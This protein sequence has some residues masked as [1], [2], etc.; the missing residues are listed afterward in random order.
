MLV[1]NCAKL[2]PEKIPTD[3]RANRKDSSRRNQGDSSRPDRAQQKLKA[4]GMLDHE[5][6]G[7]KKDL[8]SKPIEDTAGEGAKININ[9]GGEV[10]LEAV[11]VDKN[12]GKAPVDAM[13]DASTTTKGVVSPAPAPV[14]NG[15]G[16]PPD[17]TPHNEEDKQPKSKEKPFYCKGW[18]W[19][20]V[21]LILV[22]GA[23]AIFF[24]TRI[25]DTTAAVPESETVSGTDPDPTESVPTMAPVSSSPSGSPSST[26]SSLVLLDLP[27]S[28]EDCA[29]IANG[30]VVPGQDNTVLQ[31]YQVQMDVVLDS[32]Y[33]DDTTAQ[34]LEEKI[35]ALFMPELAGC[36]IN[37]ERRMLRTLSGQENLSRQSSSSSDNVKIESATTFTLTNMIIQVFGPEPELVTKLG[38]PQ[39]FKQ[40][41]IVS[42]GATG[43]G[44]APPVPPSDSSATPS[45]SP[46]S[47]P[48]A[49]AFSNPTQ[50]PA[51]FPTT[52]EPTLMPSSLP[53]ALPTPDI[54]I[55]VT[56]GPTP[57][58]TF[59]PVLDATPLP[60]SQPSQGPTQLP[61]PLRTRRPAQLPSIALSSLPSPGPSSAPSAFDGLGVPIVADWDNGLTAEEDIGRYFLYLRQHWQVIFGSLSPSGGLAT[62]GV[63]QKQNGQVI[64]QGTVGVWT[65]DASPQPRAGAPDGYEVGRVNAI[66]SAADGQWQT[67]DV[68]VPSPCFQTNTELSD[69]VGDW[70]DT[71]ELKGSVE[72]QYGPIAD[73]CFGAGVTSMQD[74]FF[75]HS[76]FNEDIGNWDVSSITNMDQ[77]FRGASVFNQDLSSWD[78]SSATSMASIINRAS[79][80]FAE[81]FN[82]DISSWD[83]SRVTNLQVTFQVAGSFNQDLSSWDVSS[84]TDVGTTFQGAVAFNQ[85]ISSWDVSSVT[86]MYRMFRDALAFDQDY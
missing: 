40:A 62:Y 55:N 61:T 81:K 15:T 17:T 27:P 85:D 35:Q 4:A 86:S 77:M 32:E 75:E 83:V 16:G 76:T 67:G 19:V 10:L 71:P 7:Q 66:R 74:L 64:W 54:T 13:E 42:M 30:E 53:S 46:S 72:D 1:E 44:P 22:G 51:S 50:A 69:A 57:A 12:A 34:E 26:P 23:V 28:S 21:L 52:D 38:L 84:V 36:P 70:F 9:K 8:E 73:W 20:V 24:G 63:E 65:F 78:V 60:P 6:G 18:F 56:P 31:S 33:P 82:Q 25:N 14:P 47:A 68:I 37:T 59:V 3:T 2:G 49:S 11:A 39:P 45:A 41:L 29:A 80:K 58:P 48:S 5:E 79:V 43:T